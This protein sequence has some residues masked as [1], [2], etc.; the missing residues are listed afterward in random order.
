LSEFFAAFRMDE[1]IGCKAPFFVRNAINR[2]ANASAIGIAA[3]ARGST[4][5]DCAW[6]ANT[7]ARIAVKPAK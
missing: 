4:G 1:G 7:I 3:I 5:F 2:K 6:T